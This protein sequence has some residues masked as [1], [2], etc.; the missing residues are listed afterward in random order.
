[1]QQTS[2][3]PQKFTLQK[4]L[5]I[6]AVGLMT[7]LFLLSLYFYK[8]RMLFIDAP[9]NLFLILNDG[10]FHIEE[11]RIGSF[12]SQLLPFLGAMVHLPY[13]LIVL[14]YSG[15][16]NL[17]Y[18]TVGLLLLFRYKNY[19][20]AV[21]YAFYLTMF[22]SATFYWPN[23]EV[24]QGMGW[25]MLAL[26]SNLYIAA[27][28]QRRPLE[29][30]FF[31]ASFY[32]AIWTHPL[33]MLIALF[34]WFFF[35]MGGINWPFNKRQSIMYTIV[36]LVLAG[37][38]FNTGMH[39]GY[40]SSKIEAVT[41]LQATTITGVFQSYQLHFF[42]RSCITNYWLFAALLSTGIIS[43]LAN[44]KYLLALFTL[45]AATG[46]LLLVC[47]TF[48]N[49]DSKPFYIESEFMPLAV[50]CC[51]PFV[52]FTL[53]RFTVRYGAILTAAI[54]CIRLVYILGAAAPFTNRVAI[55]SEIHDRL[56]ERKI[57]KAIITGL[58]PSTDSLLILSWGAP[59]ESISLSRLTGNYPQRTFIFMSP[60]EIK[61]FSTASKDTMLGCWEKRPVAKLNKRYFQIDTS[62]TYTTVS[63]Q[64]LMNAH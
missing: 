51:A 45:V 16:F 17:F 54:L 9:H 36:L 8:E 42:L 29:I 22:T 38:K 23:N 58:P 27:R 20:L 10:R 18:L 34:L 55:L 59:V 40:D 61:A 28:P 6:V 7:V 14:L 30:P 50:I 48:P 44:R 35:W 5:A 64:E 46:Y 31:I 53:P 11:H 15:S 47:I 26:A 13:K 2:Q 21:L 41:N 56:K 19:G 62:A 3:S 60:E 24:H 4:P 49:G 57:T 43:L 1:M 37:I 52:F 25:L 32:L 39:H 63:Y 12:I 33:I